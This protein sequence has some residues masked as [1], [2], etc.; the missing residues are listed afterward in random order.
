MH[1]YIVAVLF[2][3]ASLCA[4]GGALQVE[5]AHSTLVE[6]GARLSPHAVQFSNRSL[7]FHTVPIGDQNANAIASTYCTFDGGLTF[8]SPPNIPEMCL[9][10]IMIKDK[11]FCPDEQVQQPEDADAEYAAVSFQVHDADIHKE[12]SSKRFTFKGD[13]LTGVLKQIFFNGNAVYV[14]EE[15]AY[16]FVSTVINEAEDKKVV[17]FRSEDG[18]VYH[19]ISAIPNAGD[20]EQHYLI[21]EG[22]QRLS[23]LS[24][25]S[26]PYYK[27]VTSGYAGRY[28]SAEKVLN[29]SAPPVSVAFPSGVQMQ[30]SCSNETSVRARWYFV[31]DKERRDI[32]QE[33]PALVAVSDSTLRSPFHAFSVEAPNNSKKGL[34]VLQADPTVDPQTSVRVSLFVLD[35][36][37]EE[38][39]RAD[40]IA[41][42]KEKWQKKEAARL[43]ASLE[44]LKRER[45]QR[46]QRK[47]KEAERKAQFIALDE[48]N[49]RAAKTFLEKDGEMIIIRRV[50]TDSI[51]LEKEIFFSDL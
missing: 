16:I 44:R 24:S 51:A 36:S 1:R 30:Y 15:D 17:V 33:T 35:D 46:L 38:K 2:F 18:L 34:L 27:K 11:L 10:G 29:V 42:E 4:C 50:K 14:E 19:P 5:L 41:E 45:A 20:A 25:F 40:K 37:A 21:N 28:W 7:C 6:T 31:N 43:K 48:P 32:T 22:G 39:E 8:E 9:R 26:G 3:L 12:K 47:R 23:V 13:K 49:V